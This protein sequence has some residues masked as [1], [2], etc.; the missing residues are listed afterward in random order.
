MADLSATGLSSDF[1]EVVDLTQ[2]S[3]CFVND[4]PARIG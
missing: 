1:R 3:V 4:P 2:D